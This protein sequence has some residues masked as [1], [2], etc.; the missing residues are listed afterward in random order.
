M[1]ITELRILHANE[2]RLKAYVTIV[3]DGCF[4]VNDLKIIHGST[5]LFVAMPSKK[6][7]DGTYKDVAH[8]LN[9][10]TRKKMEDQILKAYLDAIRPDGA[11]IFKSLLDTSLL[12]RNNQ[13]LITKQSP[14]AAVEHRH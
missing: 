5:G 14:V 1:E 7:K 2:K 10:S 9:Q 3:L 8:P 12:V 13:L 4:V 6:R 11:E